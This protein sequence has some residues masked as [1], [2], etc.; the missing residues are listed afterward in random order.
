MVEVEELEG[1]TVY[2]HSIRRQVPVKGFRVSV[3]LTGKYDETVYAYRCFTGTVINICTL[4]TA[5]PE[6]RSSWEVGLN[7]GQTIALARHLLNL[8]RDM[9]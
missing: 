1:L 9:D 2:D 6:E 3:D 4:N 5:D 8:A 7:K